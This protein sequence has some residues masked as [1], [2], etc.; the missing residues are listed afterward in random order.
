[1]STK[2]PHEQIA[3]HVEGILK[4]AE[5]NEDLDVYFVPGAVL[6]RLQRYYRGLTGKHIPI[7]S[8]L[9]DGAPMPVAG[10]LEPGSVGG[11]LDEYSPGAN[12]QK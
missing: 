11:T 12:P 5:Y 6:T 7:G 1:M 8:G 10:G 3:E 9:Y 4:T 2:Q